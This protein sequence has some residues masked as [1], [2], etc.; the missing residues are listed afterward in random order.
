MASSSRLRRP[1]RPSY[2]VVV[3]LVAG[4]LVLA[5]AAAAQNNSQLEYDKD[6]TTTSNRATVNRVLGGTPLQPNI[7]IFR[8]YYENIF[9]ALTRIENI[10]KFAD[11]RWGLL[12]QTRKAKNP[13]A[14]AEFNR[15]AI[16]EATKL[17]R[18]NYHPAARYNI[19]LI[20][21]NLDQELS[22]GFSSA[23]KPPVPLPEAVPVLLGFLS[24]AQVIDA[25]RVAALVGLQR[26]ARYNLAPP[27]Q[28][29][30]SQAML[31][32]LAARETPS[33]R[34]PEGHL[35][36]RRRATDVL[37]GIAAPGKQNDVLTALQ[38][39]LADADEDITLRCTVADAI[40]HLKF[41]QDAKIDA[42]N[43]VGQ[44]GDLAVT[45]L[46]ED[47]AVAEKELKKQESAAPG[48]GRTGRGG[49][50]SGGYSG[51]YDEG[52]FGFVDETEEEGVF[53]RRRLAARIRCVRR[54]LAT[55]K[56][57]AGKQPKAL[58]DNL[59]K[60]L[61]AV[62]KL[63]EDTEQDDATLVTEVTRIRGD[64]EGAIRKGQT[65]A[66]PAAAEPAAAPVAAEPA[67]IVE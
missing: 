42:D 66:A 19:A 6:A 59:I 62:Q 65:P 3:T 48:F 56:D 39:V 17:C 50:L 16:T 4:L 28:A 1:L 61:D 60:W 44:L 35:W 67:A 53:P 63:I 5:S 14:L 7:Q 55:V 11:V 8:T 21:G 45:V 34:S 38:T 41:A 37:G 9:A 30:V 54:G 12:S 25:V 51:G 20:V 2:G 31:A 47:V 23:A 13:E 24:D 32:I 57:R 22:S 15:I 58:S 43:L 46:A 49:R 64:I 18:E 40:G 29:T 27:A 36:M 26:H 52:G 33:G 10:G